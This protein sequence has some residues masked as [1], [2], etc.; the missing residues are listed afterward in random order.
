MIQRR[1]TR[2]QWMNRKLYGTGIR[3]SLQDIAFAMTDRVKQRNSPD[4]ECHALDANPALPG[5][6]SEAFPLA[7]MFDGRC[8]KS[9]SD[10]SPSV[11][12][13]GKVKVKIT[14][15]QATKAQRVRC[16]ALLFVQPRR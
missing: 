8:S 13:Q 6:K 11:G 5:H 10:T 14:L 4:N 16:I 7:L 2:G 1:L 9:P 12:H 15:E 3:G